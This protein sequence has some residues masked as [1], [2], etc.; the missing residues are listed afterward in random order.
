[1]PILRDFIAEI[2]HARPHPRHPE[3][4]VAE[5]F[6][7]EQPRLLPLPNPLPETDLITPINVDKT[8]FVAQQAP[9]GG[10]RD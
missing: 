10:P 6:A 1:M 4:S 7:E 9:R 3:R 5:V 8:A 2:A